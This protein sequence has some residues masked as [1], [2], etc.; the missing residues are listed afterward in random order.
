MKDNHDGG[1]QS[2]KGFVKEFDKCPGCGSEER[3]FE[4]IVNELK[5][6]GLLDKT[7]TN[8]DFQVQQ[9]VTLSQQKIAQLPFGSEVPVFNRR[10]DICFDCGME[11]STHLE[12]RVAKKSLETAPPPNRA[13]RRRMGIPNM[14]DPLLS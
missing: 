9:G 3:F 7:I 10:W 6:R 8:F 14:N 13:E 2:D 5:D 1:K 12:K 4:G 11:Y